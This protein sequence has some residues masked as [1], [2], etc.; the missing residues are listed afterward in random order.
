MACKRNKKINNKKKIKWRLK[1]SPCNYTA[2]SKPSF[3]SPR[4]VLI[5]EKYSKTITIII[6]IH[7]RLAL[8]KLTALY[9]NTSEHEGKRSEV[10]ATL[11]HLAPPV[12]WLPMVPSATDFKLRNPR[13]RSFFYITTLSEWLTSL[14]LFVTKITSAKLI[15]HSLLILREESHSNGLVSPINRSG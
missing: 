3:Q 5:I 2:C 13:R 10:N 4:S 14:V 12:K 8:I 1:W 11:A 6:I 7:H 15:L 9:I